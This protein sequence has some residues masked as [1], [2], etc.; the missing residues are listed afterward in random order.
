MLFVHGFACDQTMWR[1]ITPALE[2]AYRIV[3]FDYAGSSKS[4]L[5]AYDPR[6]YASLR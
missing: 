3:L 1:F 2:R 4:D 5:S 6:R